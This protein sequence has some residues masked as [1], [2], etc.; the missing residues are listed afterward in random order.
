MKS[1]NRAMPFALAIALLALLGQVLPSYGLDLNVR[2][3][4]IT[5]D[6]AVT[7]PAVRDLKWYQGES[8]SFDLFAQRN[9]A[10]LNLG[11]QSLVAR[12]EVFR[13]P[14]TSN[15]YIMKTGVVVNAA[16][17]HVSFD[18]APNEA[19]FSTNTGNVAYTSHVRLYQS[20]N[21]VG[22]VDRRDV[23]VL[24]GPDSGNTVYRGP[25]TNITSE[26][27]PVYAAAAAGIAADRV[28][29][30]LANSNHVIAAT[31]ALSV[32][33]GTWTAGTGLTNSGSASSATGALNAAS[34][35]SLALA[36]S[37]LQAAATNGLL[38]AEVDTLA[39]VAARGSTY[40]AGIS[41]STAG[42]GGL[43]VG[44]V[45]SATGS[46]SLA[47][48][49]VAQA[50]GQFSVALGSGTT[51]GA[52]NSVA[53]G[54]GAS[55]GNSAHDNSVVISAADNGA[56]S[57][58]SGQ[59]VLAAD[60]LIKIV[61]ADVQ[62]NSNALLKADLSSYAGDNITWDATDYQFDASAGGG[63]VSLPINFGESKSVYSNILTTS[64]Y[65]GPYFS[66]SFEWLEVYTNGVISH[67]R[68]TAT[69]E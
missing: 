39:T 1:R 17:G 43:A 23:W 21:F 13:L 40:T 56:I 54:K 61:G 38:S 64:T 14:D 58:G 2:N 30:D 3:F 5:N 46:S 7:R 47:A 67:Y 60:S 63:G 11:D 19:N 49:N 10:A 59:L 29:G 65:I 51:A 32:G 25:Y 24:W 31:N 16:G 28:A 66:N 37:A 55:V 6:T 15:A 26:I 52:T 22:S 62:A 27:D 44:L 34:I 12:W 69:G 8:V 35:A 18:L 4:T 41:V 68:K 36:D 33:G 42:T 45:S 53:I 20:T 48:G 50:S 57:T 9:G